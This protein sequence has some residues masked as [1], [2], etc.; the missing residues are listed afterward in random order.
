MMG[1]VG[2]G[3]TKRTHGHLSPDPPCMTTVQGQKVK[4][5]GQEVTYRKSTP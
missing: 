3:H 5:Q 4:D 2:S 1:W